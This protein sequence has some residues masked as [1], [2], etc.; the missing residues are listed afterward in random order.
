[1]KDKVALKLHRQFSHP[2]VEKISRLID[3]AGYQKDSDL[4]RSVR[5]V[6]ENCTICR[7]YR[8][9]PRR[10]VVGLPIAT[11]FNKC[12]AM[13]LKQLGVGTWIFHM[14]DAATRFSAAVIVRTKQTQEIIK[15]IYAN[16][17]GIFEPPKRYIIDNGCEFSSG[18]FRDM[19]E[20][21]KIIVNTTAAEAP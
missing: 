13:D 2:P 17:I 4:K 14:V 8:S 12:V 9:A 6:S 5:E 1:M 3:A 11:Q 7:T 19:C 10:P 15:H 21:M 18:H 20:Q 16:W